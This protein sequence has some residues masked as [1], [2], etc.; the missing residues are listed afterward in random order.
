MIVNDLYNMSLAL[1]YEK[2]SGS[3]NYDMYLIPYLNILLSENFSINNNVRVSKGLD[4]LI[5]PQII[6][7]KNDTLLYEY[8][9]ITEVLSF[10]LASMLIMQEDILVTNG[11]VFN[12]L[13][14]RYLENKSK[15]NKVIIVDIED[16]YGTD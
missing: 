12:N 8:E 5:N 9:I 6:I 7:G 1:I 13:R 3:K 4:N 16:I 10:G 2:A 15:N 14:N 11:M